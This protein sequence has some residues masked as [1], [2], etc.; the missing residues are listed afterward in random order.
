MA[1]EALADV[2]LELSRASH[3]RMALLNPRRLIIHIF[4]E[5]GITAREVAAAVDYPVASLMW[6]VRSLARCG[7]ICFEGS[8]TAD[9]RLRVPELVVATALLAAENAGIELDL[10]LSK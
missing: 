7:V 4:R 9:A 1:G 6:V 2:E 5:P 3:E 10:P 8:E